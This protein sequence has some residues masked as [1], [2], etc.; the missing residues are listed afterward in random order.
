MSQT[1]KNLV[2]HGVEWRIGDE[3]YFVHPYEIGHNRKVVG[4]DDNGL[5]HDCHNGNK[6]I[7]DPAKTRNGAV[8]YINVGHQARLTAKFR[9][10]GLLV[11]MSDAEFIRRKHEVDKAM[12]ACKIGGFITNATIIYTLAK[13]NIRKHR[14]GLGRL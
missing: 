6:R 8:F 10:P 14:I 11:K 1:V 4:I 9:K 3:F 13:I 7:C 12:I 2:I 5:V